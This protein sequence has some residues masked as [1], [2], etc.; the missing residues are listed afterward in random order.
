MFQ[1]VC[2]CSVFSIRDGR[3]QITS[4]VAR[5]ILQFFTKPPQPTPLNSF[6]YTNYCLINSM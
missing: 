2:K 1:F 4:S 5:S 6:H 3:N